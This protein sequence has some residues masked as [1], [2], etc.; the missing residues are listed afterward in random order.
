MK[1]LDILISTATVVVF[2]IGTLGAVVLI[3]K[4]LDNMAVIA[5]VK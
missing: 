2:F 4:E 5:G 1:K 3:L